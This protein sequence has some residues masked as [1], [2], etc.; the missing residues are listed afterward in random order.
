MNSSLWQI[1]LWTFSLVPP[2]AN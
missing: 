2:I 1:T